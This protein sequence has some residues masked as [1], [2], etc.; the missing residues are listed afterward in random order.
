MY[1][2]A[3]MFKILVKNVEVFFFVVVCGFSLS[4]NSAGNAALYSQLKLTPGNYEKTKGDLD[5]CQ[6]D[7]VDLAWEGDDANKVLRIGEKFIFA[8]MEQSSFISPAL[9][10]CTSKT[11]TSISDKQVVQARVDECPNKKNNQERIQT[12]TVEGDKLTFDFQI[13]NQPKVSFKC[14]YIKAKK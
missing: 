4:G 13:K 6:A 7:I 11:M 3:V 2:G 1:R 8:H 14:E 5:K 9:N 10:S 12:L